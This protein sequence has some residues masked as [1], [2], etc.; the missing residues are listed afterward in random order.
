MKEFLEKAAS[1][2]KAL[3]RKLID[4]RILIIYYNEIFKEILKSIRLSDY[5]NIS[6]DEFFT[7]VKDKMINYSL[8][9][10]IGKFFY[11]KFEDVDMNISSAEY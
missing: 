9:I 2:F 11:M 6:T 1:A 5:I 3:S 8:M 4:G 7:I 10:S